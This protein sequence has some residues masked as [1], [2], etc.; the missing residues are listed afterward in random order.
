MKKN[1]NNCTPL[2][3]SNAFD[4]FFLDLIAQ[5]YSLP[6]LGN[7]KYQKRRS[8]SEI[9]LKKGNELF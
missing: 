4:P 3:V 9:K 7:E 5:S 6:K 2:S 8:L 1:Y